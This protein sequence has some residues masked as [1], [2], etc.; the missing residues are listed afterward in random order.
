[1]SRSEKI[2]R[3][4]GFTIVIGI[5]PF[6]LIAIFQA[7]GAGSVTTSGIFGK[8][9]LLLS[10]LAVSADGA[11]ELLGFRARPRFRAAGLFSAFICFM[12]V[13]LTA[14]AFGYIKALELSGS[15]VET[16]LL[17]NGSLWVFASAVGASAVCK[18]GTEA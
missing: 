15:P 11:A 14:G 18:L 13:V 8:G 12:I 3:W 7:L 17:V 10:A 9:E 6:A 4:L 16:G 1:M 5:I 2:L